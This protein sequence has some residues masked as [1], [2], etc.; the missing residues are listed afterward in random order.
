MTDQ[1]VNMEI[2]M[3]NRDAELTKLEP[4][5]FIRAEDTIEF[6]ALEDG[7]Q[8]DATTIIPSRNQFKTQLAV[9]ND[10]QREVKAPVRRGKSSPEQVS[11]ARPNRLAIAATPEGLTEWG[12]GP[13]GR[14]QSELLHTCL[15]LFFAEPNPVRSLGFTSAV[16]GEGKTLLAWLLSHAMATHTNR[17][18]VL[19]ECD[20][21][22]P[23]FSTDLNL[24]ASPGLAEYLSGTSERTEIR[25]EVL[26]N[27]TVVPAGVGD[28]NPVTALAAL[29]E[30]QLYDRIA[31]PG[32]LVIVDLPSILGSYY[33]ALAA[34]AAESLV[35]VVRAAGTPSSLVMRARGE[36]RQ[37]RVE[38]IILNQVHTRVP[39]WLQSLL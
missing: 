33:G 7:D 25:Y 29:Q 3:N 39:R 19:V 32:E 8:E 12:S 28:G 5:S 35:L 22:R 9:T 6:E 26:P 20:W 4:S 31:D 10:A 36:L 15:P 24:P 11:L 13:I 18:V 17:H 34:Q 1:V 23:T 21:D 27:L 38:G 30:E 37:Q 16:V 2:E 14:L